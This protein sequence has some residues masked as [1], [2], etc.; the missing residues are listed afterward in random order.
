MAGTIYP[1]GID[2]FAQLPIIIDGVSPVR[3]DDVNRVRDA[4]VAVERELGINPSGTYSTVKT[5]LDALDSL[6]ALMPETGSEGTSILLDFLSIGLEQPIDKTYNVAVNI[7]Y[8]GYV[9][10]VATKSSSGT[11]QGEV[12]INGV[13]LGGAA[14]NISTTTE[15]IFHTTNRAFAPGDDLQF[16]ISSN[17]SALDVNATVVFIRFVEV[18][19]SSSGGG[20][21]DP[22]DGYVTSS[23]DFSADNVVA[24]FDGTGG[25]TIQTSTVIIDDAGKVT[26]ITSMGVNTSSPASTLHVAGSISSAIR[27]ITANATIDATDSFILADASSGNIIITLPAASTSS[28]RTYNIKRIDAT[29]NTVSIVRDGSDTIDG[30][31][32]KSL[33]IQYES[34]TFVSSSSS[35]YIF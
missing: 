22:G 16:R 8:D 23:S 12:L 4:I 15:V 29:A 27:T 9:F 18:E 3:A 25:L 14:N 33:N 20:A 21:F 32:S 31:T 11:A 28:G 30:A 17:A 19:A 7:P 13:A 35:W 34:M 6:V 5:R 10:S 24:R 1:I 2:G 26:G